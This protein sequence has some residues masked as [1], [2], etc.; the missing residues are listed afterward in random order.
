MTPIEPECQ[1]RLVVD[2]FDS[3]PFSPKVNA[4]LRRLLEASWK[5]DGYLTIPKT[6]GTFQAPPTKS[7][8]ERSF[9]DPRANVPDV[10]ATMPF[11]V[12]YLEAALSGMQSDFL[13]A[14]SPVHQGRSLFLSNDLRP[15]VTFLGNNSGDEFGM[16]IDATG[17]DPDIHQLMVGEGSGRAWT[18]S[19]FLAELTAA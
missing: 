7:D 15:W 18:L 5:G 14:G 9:Y 11:P 16:P 10:V 3:S 19:E 1:H 8:Q 6:A 13:H 12:R 4:E 17:Q 2:P